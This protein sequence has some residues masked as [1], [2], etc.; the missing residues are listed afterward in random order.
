MLS[1]GE[2]KNNRE[3]YETSAREGKTQ[4]ALLF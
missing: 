3:D 4:L 1:D 2:K